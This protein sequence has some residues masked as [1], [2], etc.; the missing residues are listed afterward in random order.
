MLDLLKA[1]LRQGNQ[2]SG[3]PRELPRLPERFR[4][5]PRL[6]ESKCR[7]GCRACADA[8]PTGAIATN[9]LRIDLGAC[10]FCP[11][12]EEACPEGAI[13]S[14]QDY[15][16]A[17]SSRADLVVSSRESKLAAELDARMRRL[18]GRSLKL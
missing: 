18:F 5:R 14:T 8:C 3:F 1:R 15:R 9:P 17:A 6:D 12:C 4:G 16:L 2:T 7:D 10:L 11:L 13:A